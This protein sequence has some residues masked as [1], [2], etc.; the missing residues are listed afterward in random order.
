MLGTSKELS[1]H[2]SLP[3]GYECTLEFVSE[4]DEGKSVYT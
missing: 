2:F 1:R 4:A 3:E